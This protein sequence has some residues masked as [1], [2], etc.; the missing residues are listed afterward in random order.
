MTTEKQSALAAL[1][2][3]N[4]LLLEEIYVSRDAASLTAKLVVEQIGKMEE[5][6]RELAKVNHELR[7]AL[8]E[9]NT[10][11]GTL[12]I[13]SHC[14]SIRDDAGYW[15]RIEEYLEQHSMIGFTH[16]LCPD[17]EDSLYGEEDWYQS[18]KNARK[19]Q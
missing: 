12:P 13:C 16:G 19:E 2:A 14:K 3:E 5:N 18:K 11:R 15:N 7:E 9:I 1:Q 10:L 17:C 4:R 8:D 6:Y